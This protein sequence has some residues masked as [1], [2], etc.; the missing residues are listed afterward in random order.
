MDPLRSRCLAVYLAGAPVPEFLGFEEHEGRTVS[1]YW[2]ANVAVMWDGVVADPPLAEEQGRRLAAIQVELASLIPP[3]T[4]PA[5]VD[6]LRSKIRAA[7]GLVDTA[8]LAAAA[9]IPA[10]SRVTIC[11]GD[12]H[13]SNVILTPDGPIVVDWFDA[14]RGDPV[15]D[16]ARTL[17][18]LDGTSETASRF[19]DAYLD[20][21]SA[22]FDIDAAVLARWRAVT[23]VARISEG[24]DPQP[25][26][27]IW[28]RWSS[29]G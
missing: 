12:L 16:V 7:A 6:R 11:H 17:V 3:V 8:L 9:E 20:A 23:A 18:L 26:L 4:L 1:I 22:A 14:S 21:A 28:N 24:L 27:D 29:S 13:P 5:Q 10:P 25:L 19:R 15:A 2:R